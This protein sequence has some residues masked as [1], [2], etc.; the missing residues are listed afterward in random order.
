MKNKKTFQIKL[1][2]LLGILASIVG[3]AFSPESKAQQTAGLE[4]IG[5]T[6]L[7]APA[8]L[9]L[10]S[11]FLNKQGRTLTYHEFDPTDPSQTVRIVDAAQKGGFTVTLAMSNF[12]K[13]GSAENI[14]YTD[15]GIVTV[16]D[17][18]SGGKTDGT[19]LVLPE[20]MESNTIRAPLDCNIPT[21]PHSGAEFGNYCE[22]D[23]DE[24]GFENFSGTEETSAEKIIMDG[25]NLDGEG[26]T[27]EYSV[28]LGMRMLIPEGT[29]PGDYSAHFTFTL[30]Q[31]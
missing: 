22:S 1:L 20:N 18:T 4:I 25:T 7:E 29:E 6:T 13:P 14:P 9:A 11:V 10:P 23:P 27:G 17:D 28:A 3:M 5:P 30:N 15:I 19:N 26:Q 8:T 2:S 24:T 12:E 16:S 31:L 21:G